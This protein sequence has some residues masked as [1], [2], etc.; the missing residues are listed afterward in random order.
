M[1][2]K[3]ILFIL[4]ILHRICIYK[5][6][7]FGF[8]SRTLLLLLLISIDPAQTFIRYRFLALSFYM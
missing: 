3:N 4:I 8:F 5:L 6:I 7:L 1:H 2:I